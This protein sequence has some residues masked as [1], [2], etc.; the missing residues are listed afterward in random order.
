MEPG[1]GLN[2]SE[3]SFLNSPHDPI[4]WP[5]CHSLLGRQDTEVRREDQHLDWS[6]LGH[7]ASK[8]I[9][10]FP[11]TSR[12]SGPFPQEDTSRTSRPCRRRG[13]LPL[14]FAAQ[15]VCVPLPQALDC[16][17]SPPAERRLLRPTAADGRT[18]RRPRWW[19]LI[20]RTTHNLQFQVP[21][22][23]LTEARVG[24][25]PLPRPPWTLSRTRRTI[26]ICPLIR[27][28]AALYVGGPFL[29]NPE[30][31][32]RPLAQPETLTA[33]RLPATE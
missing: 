21:N 16:L 24:R 17:C 33:A 6:P 32:K 12:K 31:G 15:H 22:D 19:A 28:S 26:T 25:E 9:L 18:S 2:S 14:L 23:I 30:F 13:K 29:H 1:A 3:A 4:T 20:G 5:P 8:L 27:L 11:I 10:R 7:S